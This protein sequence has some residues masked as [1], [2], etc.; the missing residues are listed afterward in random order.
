MSP[1]ATFS[2]RHTEYGHPDYR[3]GAGGGVPG[4]VYLG[5]GSGGCT[6]RAIPGTSQDHPRT[7][8]LTYLA[9]G[10]YPRPNE[11]FFKEYDE[12]SEI[13]LRI[14]LRLTSELTRID[15]RIDPPDRSPD[16]PE[17]APD[18]PPDL[19]WTRPVIRPC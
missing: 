9:S 2:P 18:D 12:V 11:A 16:G 5:W 8:I 4:V 19:R 14:D 13:G 1:T 15:P 6:G 17:M 10:P 3:H 7:H